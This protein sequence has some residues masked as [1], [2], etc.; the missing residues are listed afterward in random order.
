MLPSSIN[1][2]RVL[3]SSR[4]WDDRLLDHRRRLFGILPRD[5]PSTSASIP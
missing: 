2:L 3:N 4:V 1:R 5:N